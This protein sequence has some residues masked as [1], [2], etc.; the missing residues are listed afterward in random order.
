M[1]FLHVGHMLIVLFSCYWKI[2]FSF[3]DPNNPLFSMVI[4]CFTCIYFGTCSLS[5]LFAGPAFP[6]NSQGRERKKKTEV[7]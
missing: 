7:Y 2:F 5:K 3:R 6:S 4:I 1:H